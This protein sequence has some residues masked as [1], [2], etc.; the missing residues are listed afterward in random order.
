[1]ESVILYKSHQ[2]QAEFERYL[3]QSK[4]DI[5]ALLIGLTSFKKDLNAINEGNIK[6]LQEPIERAMAD[7]KNQDLGKNIKELADNLRDVS[8]EIQ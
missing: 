8:L 6:I 7:L 5:K 2:H 3:N 1:M 4:E